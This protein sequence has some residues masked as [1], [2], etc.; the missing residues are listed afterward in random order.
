[1]LGGAVLPPAGDATPEQE[2]VRWI[3]LIAASLI[4]LGVGYAIT[5]PIGSKF[6]KYRIPPSRILLAPRLGMIIGISTI[7]ISVL[8]APFSN[9]V[10]EGIICPCNW[11]EDFHNQYTIHR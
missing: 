7:L 5:A 4:A 9:D 3:L 10:Y 8:L 1:M 6:S 11:T 2:M